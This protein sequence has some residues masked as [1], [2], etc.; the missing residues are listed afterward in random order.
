MFRHAEDVGTANHR[1]DLP[2]VQFVTTFVRGQAIRIERTDCQKA[3][4][5]SHH[6]GPVQL[7]LGDK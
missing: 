4:N 7:P 5:L 2:S 1:V 3:Q 6:K